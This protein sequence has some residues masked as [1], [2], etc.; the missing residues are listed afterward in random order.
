MCETEEWSRS[1][2]EE[3]LKIQRYENQ[4]GVKTEQLHVNDRQVEEWGDGGDELC[5]SKT[6][7]WRRWWR[8]GRSVKLR[9]KMCDR[10][11]S[12][13]LK[14]TFTWWLW[15]LLGKRMNMKLSE[16]FDVWLLLLR[17]NS[18]ALSW[19]LQLSPLLFF[20]F[21]IKLGWLVSLSQLTTRSN[22]WWHCWPSSSL[23]QHRERVRI[24]QLPAEWPSLCNLY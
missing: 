9:V 24:H 15:D 8:G 23:G 18:F 2:V 3:R 6:T 7:A 4:N 17:L 12:G 13:G 16:M 10:R 21:P 14:Q 5:P 1:Q 11:L 20:F 22:S 19:C